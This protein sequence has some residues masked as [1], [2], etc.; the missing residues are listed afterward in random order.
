MAPEN[1]G[2]RIM[3]GIRKRTWKNK[4]GVHTC[5]EITFVVDGKLYRKS[6]YKS[7]TDAQIDMKNIVVDINTDISF[8]LLAEDYISRHCEINC[9][10]STKLLYKSYLKCNLK[11]LR[12]KLARDIK[13]RD[14]E[15][16]VLKMKQKGLINRSINE[17]VSFVKA[18]LNYGVEHEFLSANPITKFKKLPN[19]KP[20]I[21]FLTELQILTFLD[22]AKKFTPRYYAFFAT[23]VYT[24][25]RRGELI[26]LEW[27]DIDFKNNRI[28]VNKQIYKGVKLPTK[29]N[30]E[31]IIDIPDTLIEILKEHKKQDNISCKLVF[32]NNGEPIFPY[33]MTKIYFHP[34]IKKCNEVLDEENQ[35]E[36]IRFHDLRHTY[37]TY[38]LSNGIPVK[39]VQNQLGHTTA[40]MTLDTYAG[41][42]PTVKFGALELLNNIQNRNKIEH[43][44]STTGNKT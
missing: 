34:L 4:S 40:K 21:H 30:R 2:Q 14:I 23:A 25:M 43:D 22:L 10:P 28:K 11:D 33:T 3:A 13:R 39:Y 20:P 38:L 6:G 41:V 31:R 26:A 16:V 12:G 1:K 29:T 15:T 18:V 9:K 5:Y 19:V 8:G 37:A 42:M 17:R 24:G 36:K 27:S 32:H 7:K 44:L 35:I